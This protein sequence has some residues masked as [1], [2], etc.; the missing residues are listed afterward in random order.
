MGNLSMRQGPAPI[1]YPAYRAFIQFMLDN[2]WY[3]WFAKV[4]SVGELLIG[5]GILLGG[6]IGFAVIAADATHGTDTRGANLAA[7]GPNANSARV[8]TLSACRRGSNDPCSRAGS[9]N[10]GGDFRD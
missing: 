4:I 10:W 5:L 8:G 7:F 1:T 6:L 2:Q 3:V 9:E